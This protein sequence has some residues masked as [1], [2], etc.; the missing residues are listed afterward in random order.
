VA[1]AGEA[2]ALNAPARTGIDTISRQILLALGVTG[3]S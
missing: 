2:C 1:G 3:A